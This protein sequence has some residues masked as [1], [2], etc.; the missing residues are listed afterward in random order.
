MTF[1]RPVRYEGVLIK[2]ATLYSALL[3]LQSDPDNVGPGSDRVGRVA[4]VCRPCL[5]VSRQ[6]VDGR[7]RHVLPHL[8]RC[9]DV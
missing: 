1:Y 9:S 2:I 7:A 4:A 3:T 5:H 8:Q 6:H